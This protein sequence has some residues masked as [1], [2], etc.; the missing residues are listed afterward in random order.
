M[1]IKGNGSLFKSLLGTERNKNM[2]SCGISLKTPCLGTN[3]LLYPFKFNL[4]KSKKLY[5]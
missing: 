4:K 2:K 5:Q 1:G 3:K